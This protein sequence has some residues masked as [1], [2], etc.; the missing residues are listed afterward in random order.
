M[1][2]FTGKTVVGLTGGI[3]CGKTSALK[4]FKKLGWAVVSADSLVAE[5]L[6]TN[7]E[8]KQNIHQR[9]GGLGF[10]SFGNIDKP[11][12]GRIVF[13]SDSE[14]KWIESLLHPIV[15]SLWTSFIQSCSSE[16]CLVELPLLFENNLHTQFT[17]VVTMYA[18]NST[19]YQRL[20][21]RGLSL[22]EANAR[23]SSQLPL[24]QKVTRAD[25]VL[26][27]GGTNDFL[28]RQVDAL[29]PTIF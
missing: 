20:S 3:A 22:E 15:R 11:A 1:C 13:K 25:F 19:I 7:S 5:I 18:S 6:A 10:D 8:V 23:I 17:C 24:V 2:P 9:W 12:I 14:R 28:N 26:W 16:N 4:R 27:G 21:Q 29:A